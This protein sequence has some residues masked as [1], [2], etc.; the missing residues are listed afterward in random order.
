MAEAEQVPGRPPA[1]AGIPA[2]VQALDG[3]NPEVNPLLRALEGEHV[4]ADQAAP[5][6]ER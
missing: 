4:Q 1:L 2:R 3:R 5:A 6:N